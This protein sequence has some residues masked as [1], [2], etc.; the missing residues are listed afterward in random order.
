MQMKINQNPAIFVYKC[1]AM[2]NFWQYFGSKVKK[3]VG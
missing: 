1:Q 2:K 3:S